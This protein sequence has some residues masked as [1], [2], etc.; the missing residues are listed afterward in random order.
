MKRVDTD[1]EVTDGAA[2]H[3]IH[4]RSER[5]LNVDDALSRKVACPTNEVLRN[6]SVTIFENALDCLDVA[7]HN[8]N[9]V[10]ADR[11]Y[12]VDT[13]CKGNGRACADIFMEVFGPGVGGRIGRVKNVNSCLAIAGADLRG[14][15][16]LSG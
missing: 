14:V 3:R 9:H 10:W 1:L 16:F 12:M 15:R 8:K 5:A 2:P 6:N 11:P 7:E 4:W 13:G